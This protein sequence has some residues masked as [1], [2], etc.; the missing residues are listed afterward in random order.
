MRRVL[1]LAADLPGLRRV[2]LAVNYR[3]P[4]PVLARAV[5]LVEHNQERFAKSIRPGPDASGPAHPRPR[6]GRRR[7]PC[8]ACSA[9]WPADGSSRAVLART[10]RELLPAVAACLAGGIAFRADGV[11]LPLED[12]R[13]DGL[14]AAAAVVTVPAPGRRAGGRGGARGRGATDRV[15]PRPTTPTRSPPGPTPRSRPP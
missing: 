7:T 6:A 1:G 3:C 5:R 4:A 13:V 14:V 9:A 15:A 12:A 11:P 8:R 2:D 10:R